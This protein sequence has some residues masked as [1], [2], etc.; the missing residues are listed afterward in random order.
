MT[1]SISNLSNIF[2]GVIQNMNHFKQLNQWPHDIPNVNVLRSRAIDYMKANRDKFVSGQIINGRYE[3]PPMTVQMFEN[4]IRTQSRENEWTDEDGWMVLSVAE[5]LDV[6]ILIVVTDVDSD[7]LE[8]GLGGPVQIINRDYNGNRLRFSLGL[9]R[10]NNS[11]GHYQHIYYDDSDIVRSESQPQCQPPA[12]TRQPSSVGRC[13]L[14][15]NIAIQHSNNL[16]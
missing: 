1:T 4:L 13:V 7:I 3:D 14:V 6:E 12:P 15:I 16:I 10:V 8:S 5:M 9:S 2:S 11:G